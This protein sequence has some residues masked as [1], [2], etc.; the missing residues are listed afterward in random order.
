MSGLE[1]R[2]KGRDEALC[3]ASAASAITEPSPVAAAPAAWP[4]ID[5]DLLDER[6]APVPAFPLELLPQPWPAWVSTAA[7]SADA[8]ADY[9]AQAVLATAAGVS[10]TRVSI[11]ISEG[12]V[13]PL[14]LWLAVVGASSTGKSPALT[15]VGRLVTALERDRIEPHEAP[16]RIA[17]AESTTDGVLEALHRGWHG[18]LLWRD[19][20]DGCLTPL[21]GMTSARHL[22]NLEVSMLGS[23]EP[24][25]VSLQMQRGGDGLAARFLYAW[26]H[27]MPYCPLDQRVHPASDDV[28]PSLRRLLQLSLRARHLL[29]LDAPATAAFDAFLARLHGEVRRAE[30]LEAAWLGKGRGTVACLAGLFTLMSWSVTNEAEAPGEI[31]REA[32]H[33]A[34]SL[35]SDYYRP[36][37]LAFL[38]RTMPTDVECRARRVVQWLR[39]DG[40]PTVSKTDV[41]RTALAQTVN[42]K[43]TDRVLARLVEA[44]AL[45]PVDSEEPARRGR[46]ALRWQVNPSLRAA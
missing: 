13:E 42:A 33:C 35:W 45:R 44:G 10:G 5:G 16:R 4:A 34:V 19:G 8:P 3:S 9:V 40:R 32:V 7:R 12:W 31:G 29:F 20:A 28:L 22:E 26:P 39:A 6:R 41:R 2:K 25:A 27:S 30:G 23:I 1:Q 43:E 15:Q 11:C 36:H 37:A 38:Q 18:K 14:Q 17:L 24:E 46:P 21:R